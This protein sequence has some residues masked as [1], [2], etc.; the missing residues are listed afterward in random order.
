M[1]IIYKCDVTSRDANTNTYDKI[2]ACKDDQIN[3]INCLKRVFIIFFR[4]CSTEM[5]PKVRYYTPSPLHWM[6]KTLMNFIVE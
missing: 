3:Y 6:L 4:F 1:Q 5:F 2:F